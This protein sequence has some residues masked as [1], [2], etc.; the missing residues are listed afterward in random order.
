[1]LTHRNL[2]TAVVESVIEY[3]PMPDERNLLAFPLCH[4]AGYTVPVNHL[5]GGLVVL[6]RAYRARAVHAARRAPP[7]HRHRPR[8]DDAELPA[9][10]PEDR[11]V[12]PVRA[13]QHRLRRGRDA[14]RGAETGDR[15]LRP[16]RLLRLRHDRA[17]RERADVHQGGAHPGHQRRRAP[18]G[19]VRHADVPGRREGG[20]RPD[21]R[22]RS[23][24]RGRD[25]H[26]RRA[27]PEGLLAQRGGDARRPSRT[28]GS[29]PATWP[30]ATRR[31][32]STSSTG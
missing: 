9:P 26:P 17:R 2:V 22:V 13:A 19:V 14:S 11:R 15:P 12:R 32:S 7:H 25:R 21:G 10:A 23:R 27:G 3:Q 6:M 5:R 24:R 28:A 30:G 29:A 16:D 8:P 18:P 31:A 1:M 4:V 20:R